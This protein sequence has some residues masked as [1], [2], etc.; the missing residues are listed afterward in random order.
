M[1][2]LKS[3]ENNRPI[4]EISRNRKMEKKLHLHRS[5]KGNSQKEERIKELKKRFID[6]LV[7][8]DHALKTKDSEY[9]MEV[10]PIPSTSK[11]KNKEKKKKKQQKKK[12]NEKH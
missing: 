2:R 9:L 7:Y 12:K 1:H 8:I 11:L 4:D 6:L 10:L 5:M 3:F